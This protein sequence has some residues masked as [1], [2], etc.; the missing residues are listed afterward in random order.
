MTRFPS[1]LESVKDLHEEHISHLFSLS[2]KIKEE[3]ISPFPFV[4]ATLFLENS[5]R[6]K[7]SF[8]MAAIKMGGQYIDL[9]PETSS[10][11]K[12]EDLI[13]TLKTLYF[14]GIDLC[15][16]RSSMEKWPI[17]IKNDSNL[18]VINGGTGK[19]QHPTQALLDFFTLG[20]FW[21]NDFSNKNLLIM[22]DVVHSRVAGSLIDLAKIL[23]VQITLS[24]PS[25][26]L[27]KTETL[28]PHVSIDTN[29]KS[30][31]AHAD[32]IY[33]LRVQKERHKDDHLLEN[34]YAEKWGLDLKKY[35]EFTKRPW[36]LH[37]GPANIGTEI[38]QDLISSNAYKGYL[39]VK[40]SVY[41]RMAIMD[42]MI[43]AQKK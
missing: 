43:K 12:G 33:L 1:K 27:P 37:P 10:M 13:E 9:L 25:H 11:K 19:T 16:V 42:T 35:N 5:T 20:E 6:T 17:E 23:G 15:V 14:Q 31:L 2:K 22:G 40:N 30:A 21:N 32:A 28:P 29:F 24:G 41:M 18:A 34:S 7:I 8:Q 26:F 3:G 38:S 36:V 39:Q 4:L